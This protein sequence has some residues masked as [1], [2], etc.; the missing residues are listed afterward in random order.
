MYMVRDMTHESFPKMGKVFDRD[1]TT[2]KH[3]VDTLE[4][5]LRTDPVLK[6]KINDV[7]NSV[8]TP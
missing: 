2:I 4:E 7:K 8:L 5:Q 3:A 6:E 1:H